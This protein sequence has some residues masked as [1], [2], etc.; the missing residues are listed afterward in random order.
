MPPRT[1]HRLRNSPSREPGIMGTAYRADSP[2]TLLLRSRIH[3]VEPSYD[4]CSG[5][6]A[7]AEQTLTCAEAPPL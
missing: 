5:C 1:L 2:L 7:L 4:V 3:A 6:T